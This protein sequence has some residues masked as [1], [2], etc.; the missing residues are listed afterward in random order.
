MPEHS[1]PPQAVTTR[2]RMQKTINFIQFVV[3][4]QHMPKKKKKNGGTVQAAPPHLNELLPAP[5]GAQDPGPLPGKTHLVTGPWRG[6][7]PLGVKA[8]GE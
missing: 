8:A 2:T 3:Q 7:K 4:K 5:Q 6:A 1:P